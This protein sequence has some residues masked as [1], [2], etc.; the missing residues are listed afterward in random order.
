MLI[1]DIVT[2]IKK[3]PFTMK[4]EPETC[5]W[6]FVYVMIL[7]CQKWQEIKFLTF[8]AQPASVWILILYVKVVLE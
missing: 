8:Q 2:S 1:E 3:Y 7:S 4:I 6:M 5:I